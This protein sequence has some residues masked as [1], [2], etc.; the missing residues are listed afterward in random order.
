MYLQ[1]KH[2]AS[3]CTCRIQKEQQQVTLTVS[4][5]LLLFGVFIHIIIIDMYRYTLNFDVRLRLR[6]FSLRLSSVNLNESI[7]KHERRNWPTL[8]SF[9]LLRIGS[10]TRY[11]PRT[12]EQQLARLIYDTSRP[13]PRQGDVGNSAGF[14]GP[15]EYRILSVH[16]VPT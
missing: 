6:F 2:Q 5:F 1:S 9:F 12:P 14:G 11:I 3:C 16:P 4:L 7:M 13:N 15:N 10:A 8:R